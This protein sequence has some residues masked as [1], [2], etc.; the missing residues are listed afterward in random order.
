MAQILDGKK[1][2]ADLRARL[3]VEVATLN[4]S[5]HIVPGLAVVLVGNNPASEVYVRM[6][7]KACSD[8]GIASFSHELPADTSEETL[9]EQV[10]LL[11]QDPRVHGILVQLPLPP[12]IREAQIIQAIAPEKDVDGFHPLNAGLLAIG[13]PGLRPCTPM[14]VMALIEAAGVDPAGKHAVVIGRSNIVGKPVAMML[15]QAHATVTLC[16]SRTHQL[17]KVVALGDIV[18]AAVGRPRFVQGSWIKKGA[19]VID[20]GTNRLADGSLCGDCDFASVQPRASAISPS[21]GGVGPMTI[22]M[23]LANTVQAAKQS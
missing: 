15:L 18:V 8:V 16:H 23:L 14:G 20:V 9:L 7:K 13:R 10:A 1:I 21:P 17:E 2:A 5:R 11:N 12:R 6:K 22:A 4:Q 3:A 19:V